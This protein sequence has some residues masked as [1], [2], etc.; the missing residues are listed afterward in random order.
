MNASLGPGWRT[1]VLETVCSASFIGAR[2]MH[3][4]YLV[5]C[6]AEQIILVR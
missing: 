5:P 2:E 4:W 1:T 6:R 3:A